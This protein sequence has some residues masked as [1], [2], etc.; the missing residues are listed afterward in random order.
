[1]TE[2]PEF[3]F[4]ILCR[5][6]SPHFN[7]KALGSRTKPYHTIPCQAKPAMPWLDETRR[8]RT[9]CQVTAAPPSGFRKG[10]RR[11]FRRGMFHIFA[12]KFHSGTPHLLD[13]QVA[14]WL[15]ARLYACFR[16]VAPLALPVE[17]FALVYCHHTPT[18]RLH[19]PPPPRARSDSILRYCV[20]K[21]H[22]TSLLKHLALTPSH[23]IPCQA[24]PA[25]PWLDETRRA[26]ARAGLAGGAMAVGGCGGS[27]TERKL[28]RVGPKVSLYESTR[29][30]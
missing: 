2:S 28:Q 22:R 14:V 29:T 7:M 1:M 17:V 10:I 26:S 23:I 13:F 18:L 11:Q 15:L 16:K 24:K 20:G 19:P 21:Y 12:K 25:M 8:A 4:E 30:A 3:N 6:V 9:F 27:G 5:Q